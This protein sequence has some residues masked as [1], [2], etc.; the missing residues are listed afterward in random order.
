[1]YKGYKTSVF[2]K[3]SSVRNLNTYGHIFVIRVV[4]KWQSFINSKVL[5]EKEKTVFI[6]CFSHNWKVVNLK[7]ALDF[8][9]QNKFTGSSVVNP[10][11]NGQLYTYVWPEWLHWSRSK[12]WIVH[13]K[14]LLHCWDRKIKSLV[15]SIFV[16][17]APGIIGFG[18]IVI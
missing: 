18:E 14:S 1:M 17:Y 3:Q 6:Q 13:L 7:W 11:D 16:G 2:L 5:K 4:Y 10:T 9:C 8:L 15:S 12:S